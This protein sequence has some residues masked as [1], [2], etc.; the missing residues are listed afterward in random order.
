MICHFPYIQYNNTKCILIS[1]NIGKRY[2]D[3][4]ISYIFFSTILFLLSAAM[5]IYSKYKKYP[6]QKKAILLMNWI[7]SLT[8]IIRSID[9]EGYSGIIPREL[10][11]I[12]ADICTASGITIIQILTIT[13]QKVNYIQFNKRVYIKNILGIVFTW[14]FIITLSILQSCYFLQIYKGIKLIG[15]AIILSFWTYILNKTYFRISDILKNITPNETNDKNSQI[16][17]FIRKMKKYVIILNIF[18]F[19]I[20]I[21][22]LYSGISM[23]RE[24]SILIKKGLTIYDIIYPSIQMISIVICFT[25]NIR[26]TIINKYLS[27]MK[28]KE[29]EYII[30]TEY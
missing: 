10:D 19:N 3:F 5:C 20:I 13:L 27:C 15:I 22:Q 16:Y 21:F 17:L 11:T 6:K 4:K 30:K 7:M 28:K 2:D 26:Q 8:L 29:N 24:N 14:C 12:L 1:D 9:P 18:V 23:I 25:F